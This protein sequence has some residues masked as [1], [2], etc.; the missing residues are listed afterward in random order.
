MKAHYQSAYTF[1]VKKLEQFSNFFVED[2]K[3]INVVIKNF[4]PMFI[5][6]QKS[7]IIIKL[8]ISQVD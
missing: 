6:D 2:L 3:V 8:F 7:T 4:A 1:L 5:L